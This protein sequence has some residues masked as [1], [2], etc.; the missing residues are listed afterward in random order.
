MKTI[1][2]LAALVASMTATAAR[3]DD[4]RWGTPEQGAVCTEDCDYHAGWKNSMTPEC[5]T[6]VDRR[7]K[8]CTDDPAKKKEYDAW[9]KSYK[10]AKSEAKLQSFAESCAD[11]AKRDVETSMDQY[12]DS[13]QKKRDDAARQ[14]K[15]DATEVPKATMH[16]AKLE[17][18][19]K[20]AYIEGG[21]ENKILKVVLEGW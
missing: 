21:Y 11:D 3:A 14:A 18:A 12:K 4:A 13:C 7:T 16:D 9:V 6:E 8:A 15:L 1:S 20:K 5:K 19:V 10:D 2:L 17:A